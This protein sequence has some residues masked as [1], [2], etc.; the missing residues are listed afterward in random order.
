ME[1]SQGGGYLRRVVRLHPARLSSSR[2]E[3]AAY[4]TPSAVGRSSAVVE[5]P[6]AGTILQARPDQG[7]FGDY[8][9]GADSK[10]S[11]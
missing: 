4:S 8:A 10:L 11:G 7:R 5:P 2:P 6:A 3:W 9:F 1:S